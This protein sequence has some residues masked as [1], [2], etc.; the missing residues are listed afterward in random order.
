MLARLRRT[1]AF[2]A[3][4]ALS[5]FVVPSVAVRAQQSGPATVPALP[6]ATQPGDRVPIRIQVIGAVSRPGTI[7]LAEGDRLSMALARAGAAAS[8][9][10]DLT[11]VFLTRADPT[12]HRLVSFQINV[13]EALQ[14]GDVRFDPLLRQ[15]DKI[16]VPE[17]RA[18][19]FGHPRPVPG[20]WLKA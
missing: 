12:T 5:L 10:P 11:R 1:R 6:A 4:A 14:R 19:M 7:E 2:V 20:D 3:A 17:A 15:D 16:F 8:L 9:N 13:F 18:P